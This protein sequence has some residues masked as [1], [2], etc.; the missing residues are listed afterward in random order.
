M[1]QPCYVIAEAGVNH[2][3]DAETA[4]RLVDAAREAGAD[5]VKFQTFRAEEL[6]SPIAITADYQKASGIMRQYEMLKA[7]ELTEAEFQRIAE[8]CRT[9]GIEFLSTPFHIEAAD[10][11]IALGVQRLKVPSGELTNLPFLSGLA[12]KG[13]PLILSTGMSSLDEVAEA[14][15]TI[16]HAGQAS[17]A[18]VKQDTLAKRLSILHCTSNYPADPKDSNLRA[19][20]TMAEAFKV[21][22]GYSD[23]TAGI[24]IAPLARAL[25]AEIL[26]KHFTL[27]R[28]LPGPD[29]AASLEPDALA[30]MITRIH[31]VD[32]I[33]GD[34]I[35]APVANEIAM[36]T[37][38]RRSIVLLEDAV[39]GTILTEAMLGLKRPG[40][41]LAPKLLHEMAGERL[42][43]AKQAGD[44]LRETDIIP[45][46]HSE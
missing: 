32:G 36:R 1:I 19:M 45:R 35:K 18:D 40:D 24:E 2:N 7:L 27:D 44:V 5:A 41:G 6:A 21:P 38:A 13:L 30:E 37:A 26:E 15:E 8:H 42:C 39:I 14:V 31:A 43:V 11:L 28:T 22:V 17:G 4:L 3:G 29:H 9:V 16:R 20:Q 25:G 33:L 34:G 46:A 23:H 10:F 12:E